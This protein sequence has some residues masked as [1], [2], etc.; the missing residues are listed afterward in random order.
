MQAAGDLVELDRVRMHE[1]T[2]GFELTDGTWNYDT[3]TGTLMGPF[4]VDFD[5]VTVTQPNGTTTDMIVAASVH[6]TSGRA[7]RVQRREAAAEL[8]ADG[9]VAAR[10]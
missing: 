8:V 1:P 7:R 10:G 6:L 9:A 5:H 2:I 4:T 3:S